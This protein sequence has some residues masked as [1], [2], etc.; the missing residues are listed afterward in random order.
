MSDSSPRIVVV[1]GMHRSGTSA[2]TRGLEVLGV[3]LGS[4]LMQGIPGN[5]EKGFFED[6]DIYNLNNE[7]LQAL[8]HTW[9]T[10]SPI[11]VDELT[12]AATDQ[13]RLRAVEL[14]RAKTA[15]IATFGLKDPRIS[16]L[17]PFWKTVFEHLNAEVRYVIAIRNPLSVAQSL[18]KRDAIAPTQSHYLWLEHA[19]TALTFSDGCG[20]VVVDFDQLMA[21]PGL[22]LARIG[23]CIGHA[24]D[25]S[26]AR[27]KEY[28]THFLEASLRHSHFKP[29]DLDLEAA[30]PPAVAEFYRALLAIASGQNHLEDAGFSALLRK[31]GEH[32]QLLHPA[33]RAWQAAEQR[34]DAV[35]ASLRQIEARLTRADDAQVLPVASAAS[36]QTPVTE[37]ASGG[38]ARVP[39]HRDSDG[40]PA[41]D[42]ARVARLLALEKSHAK[43]DNRV[44]E[45]HRELATRDGQLAELRSV[46]A[47]RNAEYTQQ[48]DAAAALMEST[49]NA[50]GAAQSQHERRVGELAATLAERESAASFHAAQ[51]AALA[52]QMAVARRDNALGEARQ[53]QL[54]QEIEQLK[55]ALLR[56]E[57]ER[58]HQQHAHQCHA[59]ELEIAVG[60]QEQGRLAKA[61]EV[62]ALRGRLAAV[63]NSRLW[64]WLGPLRRVHRAVLAAQPAM[65]ERT[66]RAYRQLPV[67]P[68]AKQRIK[69]GVFRLT[70]SLFAEHDSYRRWRAFRHDKFESADRATAGTSALPPAPLAARSMPSEGR[71]P[72]VPANLPV[73]DGHWEWSD[74]A[75]VKARI[76]RIRAE[77]LARVVPPRPSLLDIGD[78]ALEVAAANVRLPATV[79][80]PEVSVIVPVFNNL[81]ITLECLWSIALHDDPRVTF[82]VIVADDSST[83]DTAR[84]CASIPNLRLLRNETNLGFLRNCNQALQHVRGR[85]TLYLNND[86]QVTPGW[87]AALVDTFQR[88]PDAGAAGPRVIYPSGHLQEAG[89]AFRP[90]GGADMVGL[91]DDPQAPRYSYARRVDYVSGACLMLPTELARRLGGFSEEFLPCYCEDGDLCLQVTAAGHAVYYNPAATVVHHLSKTT[92]AVDAGL[93]MRAITSNIAT[94]ARKWPERLN[95]T[96]IP[97]VIAFYLP[98]FHPFPE[99]DRWW[100]KGFTEWANVTRARPNFAGHFQPRLPAD[101]GFYDLRLPEIMEHQ[102]ELAQRYGV[103]GFCHYYYWFGGKRLLERP[104]EQMLASGKPDFPFCLCWANENWTRRWD[105]QDQD[106]LIAQAHSSDDD[107]AVIGDLMRYFRDRRYIRIDGRPLILVYRVTLFP[108]FAATAQRW[109]AACRQQGIGEIYIAMVE[110]LELVHMQADPARFGCD[111]SVEFPPQELAETK[112]PGGEIINPD[113]KGHVADYRDL[114]A[115]FATREPPGYT[116]FQGVATGWD[117]TAR[118]QHTSFCFEH[119]TPGAFQAWLEETLHQ[120]RLQHSGDARL[121]FVNAWNE[122]AE[123]AY[124]EPDL[125]FGHTYLEAVRNALDAAL[126]LRPPSGAGGA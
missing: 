85:Y 15:G 79:E 8:G 93:K 60:N 5:N 11:S 31:L 38:Q 39:Q 100:G 64:R 13:F 24:L 78:Q 4:S 73:A 36:A 71:R 62:E 40:A 51:A 72:V 97:R 44:L 120:T 112:A 110:S 118:R 47:L 81:R 123:G 25:V 6:L 126:L 77:R 91:N 121:V 16:R 41:P 70:G 124:L 12:G 99:N 10:W 17:L 67:S 66:I 83:D 82:E 122:W 102:V 103:H 84:I 125:R 57:S 105:G 80:R 46:L 114:A 45:L 14:L 32:A 43:L 49:A 19:L 59:L 56:I 65:M 7:I 18:A 1:L 48:I 113:F 61:A 27:F 21:D 87:L 53:I 107:L 95:E 92:D 20:R 104:I 29:R 30:L 55:A 74:Y 9:H 115:R 88:F 98:Q 22:A 106:V 89:V 117:N 26:D 63:E 90:D 2:I 33:L 75:P 50:L 101:L 94:L 54:A 68:I 28:A 76:Q 108:D 58:A 3:D 69:G 96:V 111:A 86:V 116:R 37:P 109:R 35:S 34:A 42:G 23:R 52:E 119:A